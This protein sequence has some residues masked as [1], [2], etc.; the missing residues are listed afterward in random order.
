[1]ASLHYADAHVMN[2]GM[3]AF[4]VF[5]GFQAFPDNAV[6]REVEHLPAVCINE[7]CTWKGTI[8]EYEVSSFHAH[9]TR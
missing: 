5:W 4:F 2:K 9:G 3:N 6:R 1:M 7:N 8:K